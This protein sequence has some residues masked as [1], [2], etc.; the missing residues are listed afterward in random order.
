[1]HLSPIFSP[2]GEPIFV[3]GQKH[4]W[5]QATMRG[6]NV[7]L[8]WL[9]DGRRTQPCLCIWP[10][11]N[12]FT[13]SNVGHGVWVIGRRA[14]T[15]F[16]GFNS[17]GTC[18][19]LASAHCQ[20][21]ARE[22]LGMMGKDIDDLQALTALCDVVIRFAPDLVTMPVAPRAVAKD[23]QGEAMWDL[24]TTNKASGKILSEV[25]R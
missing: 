23:L 16:V 4:S 21:E 18:T 17:D 5:H 24:Q 14:M 11:S 25:S 13:T 10:A 2:S 22:A 12:I 15:D 8:E 19:G 9:G 7:S 6:F 1:M 20:R 3:V